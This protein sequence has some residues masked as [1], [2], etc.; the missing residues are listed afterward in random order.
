MSPKK[1]IASLNNNT[2]DT[3]DFVDSTY[4]LLTE[5]ESFFG[6]EKLCMVYLIGFNFR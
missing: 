6:H 1:N 4:I 3:S 5:N 2:L